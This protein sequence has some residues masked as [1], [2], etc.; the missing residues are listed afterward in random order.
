MKCRHAKRVT[1]GEP[2][3][4]LV[5]CADCGTLVDRTNGAV[6]ALVQREYGDPARVAAVFLVGGVLWR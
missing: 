1:T 6:W 3:R 5:T 2:G 4:H